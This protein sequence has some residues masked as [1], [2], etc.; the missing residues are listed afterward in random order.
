MSLRQALA[1][2]GLSV[3]M[4]W[5]AKQAADLLQVVR[6]EVVVLDL[7]LPRRDGYG[8]VARLGTV[9]PVPSAVLLPGAEDGSIGF[10]PVLADPAHAGRMLTVQQFLAGVLAQSEEPPA[11]RRQKVRAM[12]RK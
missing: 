8:I 1:R 10:A 11:E 2:R 3:S 6:P 12:G 5:D 9:D 4:A 7:G